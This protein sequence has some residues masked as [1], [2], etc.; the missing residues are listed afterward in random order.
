MRKVLRDC[1][2]VK[3]AHYRKAWRAGTDNYVDSVGYAILREDWVNNKTTPV[4]WEE[5]K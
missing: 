4:N 5:A 2:Y 3:E 1:G